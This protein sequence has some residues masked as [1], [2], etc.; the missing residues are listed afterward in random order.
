[1]RNSRFVATLIMSCAATM[2]V[3]SAGA[4]APPRQPIQV[5]PQIVATPPTLALPERPIPVYIL[6]IGR[7]PVVHGASSADT[8]TWAEPDHDRDGHD[9]IVHGGDDCADNDAER[10]P[11]N[12]EVADA[13]GHD[14]DCNWETIGSR[15]DDYDGFVDWRAIS[16]V[17]DD[18]GAPIAV[19]RGP[20]CDDRRRDT[21]PNMPEVLGDNRDNNCDG[22]IDIFDRRSAGLYCAP[23]DQTTTPLMP[24]GTPRGGE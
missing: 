8:T 3:A 6:G 9:A 4:Q 21:N 17:R 1:M 13:A 19:I 15:D 5:V 11:G 14:E 20:D 18:S 23:T 10:F 7:H 2:L 24:C 16:I 22:L 12:P